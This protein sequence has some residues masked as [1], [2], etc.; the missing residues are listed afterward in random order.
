M[1]IQK[2]IQGECTFITEFSSLWRNGFKNKN[3]S[4]KYT[5]TFMKIFFLDLALEGGSRRK[6]GKV[7]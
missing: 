1:Q 2:T 4:Y 3:A 5:S 6:I 7:G